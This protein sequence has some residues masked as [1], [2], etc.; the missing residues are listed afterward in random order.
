MPGVVPKGEDVAIVVNN[1]ITLIP[2]VKTLLNNRPLRIK[3]LLL[4]NKKSD[5]LAIS[6]LVLEIAEK[7]SN[8]ISVG[9]RLISYTKTF[10]PLADELSLTRRLTQEQP[11]Y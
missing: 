10:Y 8:L 3:P 9:V 5:M 2:P 1:H 6:N 7:V 11:I 4:L